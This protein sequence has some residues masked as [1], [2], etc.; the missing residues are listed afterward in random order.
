LVFIRDLLVMAVL[1]TTLV[2]VPTLCMGSEIGI[3]NYRFQFALAV[4]GDHR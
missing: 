3:G 1:I 2:L 4:C